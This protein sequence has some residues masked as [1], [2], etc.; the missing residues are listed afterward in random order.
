[1]WCVATINKRD[2]LNENNLKTAFKL[3]DKEDKGYIN[4][5]EIASVLGYG[6]TV[7]PE[8]WHDIIRE[9]DTDND[10]KISFE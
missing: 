6:K 5:M 8:V 3:F 1:M 2:I 7:D 9:V 4:A 10:G